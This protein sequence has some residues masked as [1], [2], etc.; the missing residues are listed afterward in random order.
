MRL[1]AHVWLSLKASGEK[2][3][4]RAKIPPPKKKRGKLLS[5]SQ[6]IKEASF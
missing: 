2:G 5:K 1:V 3:S 4:I 6:K